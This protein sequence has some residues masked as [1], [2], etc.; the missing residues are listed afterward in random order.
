MCVLPRRVLKAVSE[1]QLLGTITNNTVLHS[2]QITR[3]KFSPTLARANSIQR[4]LTGR[5]PW[6]SRSNVIARLASQRAVSGD[7]NGPL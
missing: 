4:S 6:M 1:D 5:K 7:G 3:G 2:P